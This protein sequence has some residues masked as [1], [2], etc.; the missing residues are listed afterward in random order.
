MDEQKNNP[1]S[2]EKGETQG[3]ALDS[4]RELRQSSF[5]PDPWY[6]RA[7][8]AV[9]RLLV[10][11]VLFVLGILID[12]VVGLWK[13]VKAL[14]L[15]VGKLFIGI[16][17]L[18]RTVHRIFWDVDSWGKA[19]FLVQGLGNL[20][21]K[22]WLDGGI[23]LGIE[24]LFAWFMYALGVPNLFA[25][26]HMNDGATLVTKYG[27]VYWVGS[28]DARLPF[29]NGIF[30]VLVVLGYLVVY[31][32]GI[33]SM[34]DNY[35]IVNY[36]RFRSAREQAILSLKNKGGFQE[37]LAC[38]SSLRIKKLM[39]RKYAYSELEARYIARVPFRRAVEKE[40]S[41]FFVSLHK[42]SSFF[43]R[44]YDACRRFL[45]K[46][47]DWTS[48]LERFLEIREKPVHNV[49]GYELVLSKQEK[50]LL[51]FRHTFDK[52]N[53]Y[54]A[55][56]RDY[57]A[58]IRILS[59]G[60]RVVSS[61][62]HED[63][64]AV[65]NGLL[66]ISP[67][68]RL[69][70]K[71]AESRIIGSFEVSFSLSKSVAR[72]AVE[73]IRL[74][75]KTRKGLS[76]DEVK[77]L[78]ADEL[79]NESQ[80]LEK[81]LA[82]FD[83]EYHD[84]VIANA[85]AITKA[86][87]SYAD[88]RAFFDRGEHVF[89]H[90]LIDAW[91][92]SHS[93]ALAIYH[94]YAFEI[95]KHHDRPE[96][97]KDALERRAS[98][99]ELFQGL[100]AGNPFHGQPT[101]FV[102]RVK[103]FGDEKFAV[104]V[105]SLPVIAAVVTV[106]I[107]LLCSVFVAFTNWDQYHVNNKFVWSLSS[108]D[109]ILN[110]FNDSSTGTASYSYTF[111]HLLQWTII[112]AIFAT[113][114]NYFFGILLALIINRKSIRLKKMW[115]TIFVVTIAVPQFISLLAMSLL[116]SSTGA[117][118]TWLMNQ[119]WYANV[120]SRFFG[121]GTLKTDGTWVAAALPFLGGKNAGAFDSWVPKTTIILVNMWVGIPYTMLSTSG[122]LMNIPDDLY[123]SSRIDGASPARQLV[124]ITM[125]YVFFVTGPALLT[126]FIGNINNFNVIYFLTGGEPS[127]INN[128]V[129]NGAG[130]TD[131]LITWLYKMTVNSKDYS[132]GAVIGCLVFIVCAFFSLIIY[133]RLGSVK[134]EEEFQ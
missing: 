99:S 130:E 104:T 85:E 120:I 80:A 69:S 72:R 46:Y 113:F 133:G 111:F 32:K 93:D 53:D 2:T 91:H 60:E 27:Q 129:V 26:F 33:Q 28:S 45:K 128:R 97:I 68:A 49:Y 34:Y 11:A 39:R 125:P 92:V 4:A 24:L 25:F 57:R 17:H 58:L 51:R 63:E 9:L 48:P 59:R 98:T 95:K 117:V 37:N 124:S 84:D 52:Y 115:R 43:Y 122:I 112:W 56:V 23:F 118:N 110:I 54:Y 44:Y 47:T 119:D 65:R 19:T 79:R 114:T 134:N 71:D 127:A 6:K 116:L 106:I 94:D 29:I 62:L 40:P 18:C 131:L 12:I 66:P 13:I 90:T 81:R 7:G 41:W 5:V 15:G 82:E 77:A 10:K 126:Q 96:E 73:A 100:V 67:F 16:G 83:S 30:T 109:K 36:M 42:V 50:D 38:L 61:V 105:L 20:R 86:Y 103:E 70:E 76:A 75:R 132:I 3:L 74:A 107:P 1:S 35:Q 102:K 21:R 87:R 89:V 64:V 123:E 31:V 88:L 108:F 78:A 101:R 55:M 8:L 14:F 22:Q 121:W